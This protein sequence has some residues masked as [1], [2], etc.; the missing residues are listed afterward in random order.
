MTKKQRYVLFQMPEFMRRSII[1]AHVFYIE[2]ARK[3]LLKQFD[4]LEN[5]EKQ[6]QV[7]DEWLLE[8]QYR[9]N[10]DYHDGSE[11]YKKALEQLQALYELGGQVILCNVAGMYYEWKQ[12]SKKW[13]TD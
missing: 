13:F 9:F 1:N 3:L 2:Q 6:R 11:Y 4:E 5:Q 7:M 8:N 12:Q 10:P